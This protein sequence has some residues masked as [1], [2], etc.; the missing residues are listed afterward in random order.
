MS[1]FSQDRVEFPQ[2]WEGALAGLF[3]TMLTSGPGAQARALFVRSPLSLLYRYISCSVHC[4]HCYCYCC[5]LFCCCYTVVLNL[6]LSQPQ[7]L[8]FTPCPVRSEGGGEAVAAWSQVP[9]GPKPPHWDIV[10]ALGGL[11]GCTSGHW[12]ILGY[13]RSPRRV[14]GT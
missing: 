10:G 5:C 14:T 1:W 9:A 3:I 2:Q 7:A 13:I 8:Y 6:S 4:Y 11:L 12:D